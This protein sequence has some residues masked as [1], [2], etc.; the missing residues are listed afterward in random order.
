MSSTKANNRP[1]EGGD[2]LTWYKT[3]LPWKAWMTAVTAHTHTHLN[4]TTKSLDPQTSIWKSEK[5]VKTCPHFPKISSH[6]QLKL[7]LTKPAMCATHTHKHICSGVDAD[8]WR[9][10]KERAHNWLSLKLAVS[11]AKA[12]YSTAL[13]ARLCQHSTSCLPFSPTAGCRRQITTAQSMLGDKSATKCAGAP[14]VPGAA[15]CCISQY[16]YLQWCSPNNL[17]QEWKGEWRRK[18]ENNRLMCLWY[19]QVKVY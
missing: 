9:F 18:W 16:Y 4:S 8:A 10:N 6:W 1:E 15:W 3:H 2:H 13:A 12:L 7:V 19:S 5:G 14:V 17:M 11:A